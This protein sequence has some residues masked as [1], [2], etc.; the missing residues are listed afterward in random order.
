[1]PSRRVLDAATSVRA[2]TL[3]PRPSSS[4]DS[5][6]S[7]ALA[8]RSEGDLARQRVTIAARSAGTLF[9]RE[10]TERRRLVAHDGGE[11]FDGGIADEEGAARRAPHRGDCPA[12]TDRSARRPASP[13]P[14][15]A[16][17]MRGFRAG[18]PPRSTR[19]PSIGARGRRAGS[20]RLPGALPSRSRGSLA[21][22]LRRA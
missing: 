4:S 22:R 20:R 5:S 17:C 10:A 11:R 8:G 18:A 14:A 16:T 6:N 9:G 21:R 15:P 3:P 2:C 13:S 12:R 1:M 19:P 7:V